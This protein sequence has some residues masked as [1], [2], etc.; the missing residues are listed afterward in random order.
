MSQIE[1]VQQTCV[2]GEIYYW[3]FLSYHIASKARQQ[4]TEVNTN[5]NNNNDNNFF[6]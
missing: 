3:V 1:I 6:L 4:Y 5:A 2:T